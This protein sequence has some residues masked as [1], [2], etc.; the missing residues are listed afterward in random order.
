[1]KLKMELKILKKKKKS[2][3]KPQKN[4]NNR[5]IVKLYNWIKRKSVINQTKKLKGKE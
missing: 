5:F 3:K 1:M 4:K 2:R